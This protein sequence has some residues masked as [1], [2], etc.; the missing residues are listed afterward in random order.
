MFEPF[1]T[2]IKLLAAPAMLEQ[3]RSHPILTGA[4]HAKTLVTTYYDTADA[5]LRRGGASLRIRESGNGCEQTLK[6]I[7]ESGMSV[8]RREWN[9][10]V[11]GDRPAP[12][13]FPPRARNILA[14]LLGD[15]PLE[16]VATTRIE[17]TTR[18]LRFGGS[19]IEIAFDIGTIEAGRREEAVCELELELVEGTIGDVL[20]LVL[21]LPLGPDLGWATISKA[22]RCYRLACGMELVAVRARPV[23]LS[24]GMD[25]AAGFL[26]ICWNCLGQLIANYR[27]VIASGDAEAVHQSRVAIRRLRAACSLFEDVADDDDA[28]V[29]RAEL[30]AAATALGPSRDLHVIIDHVASAAEARHH[31]ASELLMHLGERQD[32]ATQSARQMMAAEPFQRLLFQF[33]FWLERGAWMNRIEDFEGEH[34]LAPFA[35][36]ALSRR[37]RKMRRYHEPVS[38]MPDSSRHELRKDAKKFRYAAEFF[39]TLRGGQGP[40]RRRQASVKALERLQDSL[41]ELNDMTVAARSRKAMFEGLDAIVA[42]RLAAQLEELLKEHRKSRR[43]LLNVAKRSLARITGESAW[44]KAG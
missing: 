5:R 40:S 11:A 14:L 37:R 39:A 26:A 21:L 31:D 12:S 6:L 29:L 43:K 24:S 20:A 1:E 15:A 35:S 10:A 16:P 18:R 27:L 44:W 36:R 33:A 34:P 13:A 42:A 22:E 25:V 7:S 3:L 41:G 38:D 28:P 8:R 30:K 23:K 19:V 4:E 9:E 32:A 17:R 2:E